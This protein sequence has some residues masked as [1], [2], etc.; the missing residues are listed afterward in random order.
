VDGE[1]RFKKL[2]A[3]LPASGLTIEKFVLTSWTVKAVD[4][5]SGEEIYYNTTIPQKQSW[6][7][8]E[9]ALQDVGRLIGAEFS[10]SFFLQ[11]FDF[12]PK[13]ARLRFSGLPPAA[14]NA[15][16]VAINGNLRVLNAAIAPQNGSDA[17][18]GSDAVIDTELSAGSDTVPDLIQQ[19]LLAPLN[20]KM[21]AACFTL[22]SGDSAEIHIQLDAKCK[23]DA[24]LNKLETAPREAL[25][26]AASIT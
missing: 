7:T 2:S 22:A 11:Y 16:L 25:M 20:Q 5:K 14:G 6:A 4:A 13:K 10:Q 17:A 9:L 23:S 19:A 15:I 24:T 26:G 8:Q 1:V 12:K 21:G 3:K 18:D